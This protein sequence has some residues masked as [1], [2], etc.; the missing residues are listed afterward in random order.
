MKNL[1]KVIGVGAVFLSSFLC[2]AQNEELPWA[3]GVGWNAVDFYPNGEGPT[4]TFDPEPFSEKL[5]SGFFNAEDHYNLHPLAL[6][7]SVGKNLGKYFFVEFA[8][9]FNKIDKYGYLP[10]D[11]L[12]YITLDGSVNFSFRELINP[13]GWAEPFIGMGAGLIWVEEDRTRD[14]LGTGS[15]DLSI[16]MGIWFTERLSIVLRSNYKNVGYNHERNDFTDSNFQHSLGLK[17]SFFFGPYKCYDF[18]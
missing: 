2:T 17:Y 18:Q 15:L 8:T 13:M 14:L 10:A 7:L 12:K 11:N 1:I 4:T 6:R 5:F 3:I 9:S 16:G